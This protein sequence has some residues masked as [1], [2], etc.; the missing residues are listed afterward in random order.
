MT[1]FLSVLLCTKSQPAVVLPW[2]VW[3][4][5]Q[6]TWQFVC[7]S[8]RDYTT[9]H[10]LNTCSEHSHNTVMMKIFFS[11]CQDSYWDKA[12][13]LWCIT[14]CCSIHT[15]FY[16][17]HMKKEKKSH[18]Q[19]MSSHASYP[20][21]GP[22]H[23]IAAWVQPA[24][25]HLMSLSHSRQHP[26]V[27][28]AVNPFILFRWEVTLSLYFLL[29]TSHISLCWFINSDNIIIAYACKAIWTFG[30]CIMCWWV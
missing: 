21:T 2:L 27:L 25:K 3:L 11:E 14:R 6:E 26:R 15:Q 22:R 8:A 13:C 19:T 17:Q 29:F 20:P 5:T 30:W 16:F 18:R 10:T 23:L 28:K 12:M 7:M 24:L 1:I 9:I 4:K